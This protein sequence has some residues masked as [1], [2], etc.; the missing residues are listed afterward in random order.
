M[1][2][3]LEEWNMWIFAYIFVNSVYLGIWLLPHRHM[4]GWTEEF[5]LWWKVR[6]ATYKRH[7]K[8]GFI[9]NM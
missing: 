1:T 2:A 9:C 8:M 4:P 7:G 3:L 5:S 6:E